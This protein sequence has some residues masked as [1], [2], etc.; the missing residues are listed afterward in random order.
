MGKCK[1]PHDGAVLFPR[2]VATF[3]LNRVLGRA[4]SRLYVSE[5]N[6]LSVSVFLNRTLFIRRLQMSIQQ[7]ERREKHQ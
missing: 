1:Q 4:K 3:P 6:I 7:K 5:K 2:K